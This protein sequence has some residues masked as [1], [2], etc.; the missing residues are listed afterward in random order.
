MYCRFHVSHNILTHK[1]LLDFLQTYN[2]MAAHLA[3]RH[4]RQIAHVNK[5]GLQTTISLH[6]NAFKELK[7]ERKA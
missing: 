4:L 2:V 6:N 3:R 7:V 5:V 1:Y